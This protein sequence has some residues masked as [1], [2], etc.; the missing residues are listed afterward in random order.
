ML[1]KPFSFL[2]APMLFLALAALA[3]PVGAAV[4]HPTLLSARS[5]GMGGAVRALSGPLESARVNPA[6]LA[7]QRGFFSGS[8]Y[9][10]R[11]H[12]PYDAFSL[13]LVDNITSP[14]GGALQYQRTKGADEE[15]EEVSLGLAMG[16]PGL[17]WGFTVRYVHGRA[18]READWHNVF[19][20]DV[21]VLFERPGGTRLA[22]VGYDLL[23]T[24]L[25]FLERRVAC[26]V[27]QTGVGGSWNLAADVV[28]NLDRD[29]SDGLDLH[30]G[31]EHQRAGS[32][33]ATRLGHLWRG[34]SGK[35]YQSLGAGYVAGGLNLGYA[36]QLTRQDRS[37]IL[38]LFSI[39]G[40]F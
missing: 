30:L 6:G 34:D 5:L 21:G 12:A 28:R 25:E 7:T 14:M 2:R 3:Q 16:Q 37:E 22:V 11:R 23:G 10:T 19:E 18:D 32:P 4:P 17:R 27:A 15:R 40:S 29:F 13:T 26:G 1:L 24:S 8:S 35:D 36:L 38:H 9:A 31:A 39:D 33:W 20:G